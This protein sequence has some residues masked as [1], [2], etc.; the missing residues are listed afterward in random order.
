MAYNPYNYIK[1]VYDAKVGWENATT[2]AERKRYE[3]IANEARQKL[4]DYDYGTLANA[5]SADGADAAAVKKILDSWG[6]VTDTGTGTYKTGVDNPA[7]NVA[8]SDASSKNSKRDELI[9]SDHANVNSKYTDLFNYA[10]GDVTQTAEYKS[11]FDNIMPSYNLKAMQ[12]RDNEVASGAASNGGNIDSYAA[13][14]AMRQQAALTAKGQ[15]LA[16]Q[17]GI[18][19]YQAHVQNAKSILS[20]LGVYNSGV[21]SALNDGVN[22][23][24]NIAN[25]VFAN[26]ETAKN[27]AVS[28]DV[29]INEAIGY[30]TD[31]QLKAAS[32]LWKSDGTLD[33]TATDYQDNINRVKALYDSAQNESDKQSYALAL[34]L[35]EMARNDKITQTGSTEAKTYLYQ[36]LIENANMKLSKEQIAQADR[37]MNAEAANNDAERKNKIDQIVTAAAVGADPNNPTK[38][39]TTLTGPQAKSALESGE[40]NEKVV[41]AYNAAYGGNYTVSNPPPVYKPPVAPGGDNPSWLDGGGGGGTKQPTWNDITK[42]FTDNK[43]VEFLNNELKPLW[44]TGSTINEEVLENLIVGDG[45]GKSNSAKYDIDVEDAKLL[46]DRISY[47]TGVQLDKSWLNKYTDRT[48]FNKGKGMKKVN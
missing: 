24:L 46:I 19:A 4:K 32:S 31:S 28:R 39:V 3:A 45:S 11:A 16:H 30:N 29:A 1:S 40:L 21:Y 48:W 44:D 18:D 13:A 41:A 26:S 12:G 15:A 33:N 35:L 36:N 27:N 42:D 17:A 22:N 34:K 47:V 14:N 6:N 37:L 9:Y 23:D 38:P 10:N 20:D 8:I 25:S 5:V 7:Y 2:D 43:F